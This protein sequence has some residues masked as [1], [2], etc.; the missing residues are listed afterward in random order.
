MRAAASSVA[1]LAAN[2]CSDS[3]FSSARTALLRS[4]PIVE[5][6]FCAK[7]NIASATTSASVPP[8]ACSSNSVCMWCITLCQCYS[9][10]GLRGSTNFL[11]E[12]TVYTALEGSWQS[13]SCS[14]P[15]YVQ[16]WYV[17]N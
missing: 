13:S 14:E 3:H 2:C 5:A 4:A 12:T 8:L 9:V 11:V 6:A 16:D 1:L 15:V 10:A 17:Q 7:L